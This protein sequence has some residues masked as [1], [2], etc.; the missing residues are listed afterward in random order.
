MTPST[1]LLLVGAAG[2]MSPGFLGCVD[3]SRH[4]ASDGSADVGPATSIPLPAV[5][6]RTQGRFVVDAAGARFK[7]VGVN[8]YGAESPDWSSTD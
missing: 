1:T 5:P 2:I 7:L 3:S 4:Q 6:F 8:W